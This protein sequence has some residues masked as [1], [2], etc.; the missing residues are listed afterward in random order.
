MKTKWTGRSVSKLGNQNDGIV[1]DVNFK[2]P[3]ETCPPH[4][5]HIL[6]F[7]PVSLSFRARWTV[8]IGR[9]E[10]APG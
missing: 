6:N 5:F 7:V 2:T 8:Q 4:V 9:L 3:Q 10:S 1:A